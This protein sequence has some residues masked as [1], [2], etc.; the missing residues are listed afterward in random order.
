MGTKRVGWAR[1]KSLINENTANQLSANGFTTAGFAPES[2]FLPTINPE[3]P[4]IPADFDPV[5]CSTQLRRA[6]LPVPVFSLIR[7]LIRAQP[8][9]LVPIICFSF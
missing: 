7:L 4:C 9:L 6:S 8:T 3:G 1:I 2:N 5:A